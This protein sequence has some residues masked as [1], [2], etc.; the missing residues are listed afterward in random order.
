MH[1][2][3]RPGCPLLDSIEADAL[4]EL[5]PPPPPTPDPWET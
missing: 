3:W 4:T 1:D 5:D 2:L